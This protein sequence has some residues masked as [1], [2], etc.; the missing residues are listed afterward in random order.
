MGQMKERVIAAMNLE[1]EIV[2]AIG[3]ERDADII[4]SAIYAAW[5]AVMPHERI[6]VMH[7]LEGDTVEFDAICDVAQRLRSAKNREVIT[8]E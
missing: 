5:E 7:S 6:I 3:A 4:A 8:P 1:K 2:G